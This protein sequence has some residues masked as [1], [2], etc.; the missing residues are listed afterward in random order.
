MLR[1]KKADVIFLEG[2]ACH[3]HSILGARIDCSSYKIRNNMPSKKQRSK[4]ARSANDMQ[5]CQL[6][7]QFEGHDGVNAFREFVATGLLAEWNIGTKGGCICSRFVTHN[8]TADTLRAVQAND[9]DY[10]Q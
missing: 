5:P 7:P 8:G 4:A 10:H 2:Q 1:K 9:R 6:P 3:V